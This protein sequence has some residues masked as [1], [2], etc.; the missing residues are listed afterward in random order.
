MHEVVTKGHEI[1][2]LLK[3]ESGKEIVRI[4]KYVEQEEGQ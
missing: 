3:I 1:R 2:G 4:M